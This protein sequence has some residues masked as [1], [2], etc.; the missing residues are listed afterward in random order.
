MIGNISLKDVLEEERSL[1][2][3]HIEQEQKQAQQQRLREQQ[4]L[5]AMELAKHHVMKKHRENHDNLKKREEI[6]MQRDRYYK[7]QIH[8]EFRRSE[9]QLLKALEFRKAEVR[10]MYGDLVYADGAYGGSKGRRWKVDWSR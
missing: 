3:K 4:I 1:R 2:T 8:R 6:L 9:S 5:Q 10:T 7:E